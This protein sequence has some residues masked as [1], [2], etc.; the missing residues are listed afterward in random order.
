MP[1]N[2]L[3]SAGS[4]ASMRETSIVFCS[5]TGSQPDA[6]D[7]IDDLV[8]GQAGIHKTDCQALCVER[9]ILQ[10]EVVL[11]FPLDAIQTMDQAVGNFLGHRRFGV[12]FAPDEVG[13]VNG[14]DV[15]PWSV[16][17]PEIQIGGEGRI[18]EINAIDGVDVDP[19]IGNML[20]PIIVVGYPDNLA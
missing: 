17:H 2:S 18:P 8:P 16:A 20:L 5:Q 10:L 6:V 11:E 9:I 3:I 12:E 7:G 15:F 1:L 14:C 4:C 13:E 19:G